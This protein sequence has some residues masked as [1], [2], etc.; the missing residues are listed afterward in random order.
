[1]HNY[2][3]GLFTC[4]IDYLYI[5]CIILMILNYVLCI[6]LMVFIYVYYELFTCINLVYVISLFFMIFSFHL[7]NFDK[8]RP[9]FD[10][11]H[12]NSP[13]R[14]FRKTGRF[15][16]QTD[17]FIVKTAAFRFSLVSPFVSGVFQSIFRDFP[18]F[19]KTDEISRRFSFFSQIFEH[20]SPCVR[21]QLLRVEGNGGGADRGRQ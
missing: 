6:T 20:C 11:N 5:V 13:H 10:K 8:N 14:F 18:I 2:C 3:S 17:R 4:I 21:G 7:S 15:I 9:I 16:G 19:K 1:M 12:R